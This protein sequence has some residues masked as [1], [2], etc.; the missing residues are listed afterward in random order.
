MTDKAQG[1][2][3]IS[4]SSADIASARALSQHLKDR[5][6]PVW[7]DTEELAAGRDLQGAMTQAIRN[8]SAVVVL[9]S[10]D[11]VHSSWQNVELGMVLGLGSQTRGRVIPIVL[12]E[13]DR[14]PRL[15]S[16]L[17]SLQTVTT[18]KEGLAAVANSVAEKIV[19]NEW[20]DLA[21]TIS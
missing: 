6:V 8:A 3:F 20:P 15:P 16:F 7:L 12:T 14:Q 2:V 10:E 11:S 9:F 19:R 5:G 4:H 17:Q 13:R 21:M 18:N 1:H